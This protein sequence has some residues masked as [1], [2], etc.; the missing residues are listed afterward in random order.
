MGL[1]KVLFI[2]LFACQSLCQAALLE[3]FRQKGYAEVCTEKRSFDLL[4]DTFDAF[5]QFLHEHP[6]WAQKLYSAKERFLRSKERNF[7]STDFFGLYDDSKRVGRAQVSFYYSTHFHDFFLLQYPE[8]KKIP[9]IIQFLDACGGMQDPCGKIFEDA[10][11]ELSLDVHP[12]T[13]FKVIKYLPSYAASRPHYDGT[14]FSLFL[15]STDNDALLLSP[16][17]ASFAPQ[18]FFSPTRSDLSSLL[19]PGALLAEFSIYPTPHIVSQSGK[20]RYAAVA[21]AMRPNHTPQKIE[22]SALPNF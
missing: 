19:I 14:L 3:Q 17:K 21:F 12:T 1:V 11:E 2:C 20:V 16:Y 10:A 7:Y 13:L 18:D 15:D 4:Y 22:F 5:L 9:E 6:A 8:C